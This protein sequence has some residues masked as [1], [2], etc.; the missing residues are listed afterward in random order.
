MI[1]GY[2]GAD[3]QSQLRRFTK[4]NVVQSF[5]NALQRNAGLFGTGV[6]QYC[7]KFV[8][9]ITPDNIHGTQAD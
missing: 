3:V 8:P 5:L 1:I 4:N 2:A 9:A 7:A 6:R